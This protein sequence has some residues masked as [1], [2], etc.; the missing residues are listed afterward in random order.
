MITV[1]FYNFKGGA[2]KTTATHHAATALAIQGNRVLVLDTDP[3]GHTSLLLGV[4]P[5]PSLH[6]WLVR[7][8]TK[9][10]NVVTVVPREN[11]TPENVEHHKEGMLA[12]IPGDAESSF[13]PM[14]QRDAL[15]MYKRLKAI[16]QHFDYCLIDTPPTPSLMSVLTYS[17]IDAV[18]YTTMCEELHV[19]GLMRA[20]EA[21]LEAD[22]FRAQRNA[23]PIHVMGIQ[24]INFRG[25]TLEHN[26]QFEWLTGKFGV[27]MVWEPIPQSIFW[28]EATRERKPVFTYAPD[29]KAAQSAYKFVQHFASSLNKVVV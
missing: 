13:I 7:P 20:F 6:D 3:Q 29:S 22:G 8:Q 1:A 14:K 5:A 26:E 21:R 10:Q 25:R 12:V 19:N 16:S 27:S 17:A 15:F 28:A 24:P 4:Q 2:G 23:K 11:Y 9:F 18:L